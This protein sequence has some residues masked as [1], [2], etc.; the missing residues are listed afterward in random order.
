MTLFHILV[1]LEPRN[2]FHLLISNFLPFFL[3]KPI[4]WYIVRVGLLDGTSPIERCFFI[5]SGIS[6]YVLN[7]R[8]QK[9]SVIHRSA[10][11]RDLSPP[12]TSSR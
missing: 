8:E 1:T 12:I 11:R 10:D 9:A 3:K 4:F 7:I 2:P 6:Y 5:H